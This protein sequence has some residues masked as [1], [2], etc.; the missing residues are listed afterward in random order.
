M[1]FG[2]DAFDTDTSACYFISKGRLSY[3]LSGDKIILCVG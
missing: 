3:R 1:C 2:I